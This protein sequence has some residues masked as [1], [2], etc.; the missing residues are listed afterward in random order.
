MPERKA[1][2]FRIDPTA[3]QEA[4]LARYAGARRFVF[5][6]ALARRKQSYQETGQ[7][8]PWTELSAQ[9]TALKN[10]PDSAWLKQID[11][12]LL[13]QSL[14]DCK[15]AFDNFFQ[16]RAGFPKFKKKYSPHQSFRIPQR[17]KLA[18]GRVYL[19]KVGWLAIRQSQTVDLPVK[20]ATF[21]RNATGKW[22]L[23]LMVEFELPERPKPAIKTETAV[24][25]DVGFSRFATTSDGKITDNARFFRRAERK[26]KRACRR[27]AR[28]QKG[29]ANRAKARHQLAREYEQ[30]A[31]KR[32]DF[33]HKFSIDVV[34]KKQ[35]IACETLNLK[36]MTKTKLAKSVTDAA[37]RETFRQLEYKARW[38]NR[39]F[40][41]IDRWFPSSQLCSECGYRHQGLRLS[42][43]YWSCPEC[44]S[45]HDRDQNAAINVRNEGV[46]MLLAVGHTESKNAC[47]ASV[48]PATAGSSR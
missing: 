31:N 17:V 47:G 15:R 20:S 35:T 26:I 24:G 48:R 25:L 28:R 29:G 11:S 4:A 18:G 19:P 16:R 27:M 33:A 10:K 41:Q 23:C 7:S 8:I 3:E 44:G 22:H 34:K 43:R 37:H 9:L 40:V 1:Y 39:H 6:W 36:G 30:V 38:Y 14:A 42:E 21:K 13:Q 45:E 5:N 32:A 12:Q 2:R 46:R